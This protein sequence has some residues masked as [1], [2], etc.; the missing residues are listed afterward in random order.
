MQQKIMN[1]K[2]EL[3]AER[4]R[5]AQLVKKE[6]REWEEVE[7][8]K[9]EVL[10]IRMELQ[11]LRR[12][13]N[14]RSGSSDHAAETN[15]MVILERSTLVAEHSTLKQPVSNSH[16]EDVA[17]GQAHEVDMPPDTPSADQVSGAACAE[18][19]QSGG[20]LRTVDAVVVGVPAAPFE[21]F[22][23]PTDK[24]VLACGAPLPP[25][26]D[27]PEEVDNDRNGLPADCIP[28]EISTR[29]KYLDF[30]FAPSKS[31]TLQL[32]STPCATYRTVPK[33]GEYFTLN[34]LTALVQDVAISD[35]SASSTAQLPSVEPL[36]K[37]PEPDE[38]LAPTS[39][40]P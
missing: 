10:K 23:E 30:T 36:A 15:E 25:N 28:P 22:S 40:S 16:V 1:L 37:P 34:D 35:P 21:V 38:Q 39:P 19:T 17:C 5:C 20:S 7:A 8:L 3:D 14:N 2:Q 24:G 31:F 29:A 9:R 33:V 26:D 11:L 27:A 4:H 6:Q 12:Q 13:V 32:T 18:S